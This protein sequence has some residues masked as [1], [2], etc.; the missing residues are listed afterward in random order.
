MNTILYP[1]TKDKLSE[2]DQNIKTKFFLVN[3]IKENTFNKITPY[4]KCRDF[5]NDVLY[6]I[7][8]NTNINVYGFKFDQ[9]NNQFKKENLYLG[10]KFISYKAV[11]D[12]K[13]NFHYLK[14]FETLY[15]LLDFSTYEET[16]RKTVLLIKHNPFW[17]SNTITLSLFTFILRCFSHPS[18][19][20]NFWEF[21]QNTK[22]C[23]KDWDGKKKIIPSN[24]SEY[25]TNV[26]NL[27]YF[28]TNLVKINKNYKQKQY[29]FI[30]EIHHY[31]GFFS[32]LKELKNTNPLTTI[33]KDNPPCQEDVLDVIPS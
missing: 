18:I 1:I 19:T 14:K 2:E 3:K 30:Y 29:D 23:Y 33:I 7:T 22:Q 6:C 21:I 17:F 4:I 27:K 31:L 20:G 15:D 13:Q 16:N 32:F 10:L 25:I 5:L 11:E 12:F 24:E 8:F 9:I 28:I 26:L